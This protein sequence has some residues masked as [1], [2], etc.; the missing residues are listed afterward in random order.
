MVGIRVVKRSIACQVRLSGYIVNVLSRLL[1]GPSKVVTDENDSR[2]ASLRHLTGKPRVGT[3]RARSFRRLDTGTTLVPIIQIYAEQSVP[4]APIMSTFAFIMP[5]VSRKSP[6]LCH[7]TL[8]S[9]VYYIPDFFYNS[10]CTITLCVGGV[11]ENH[12]FANSPLRIL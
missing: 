5:H 8:W 7:R 3:R 1:A 12:V 4:K 11:R 10:M 9:Y 6:A 2:D